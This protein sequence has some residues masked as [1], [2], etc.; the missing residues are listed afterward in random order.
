MNLGYM[1][2]IFAD[3]KK[4]ICF[5]HFFALILNHEPLNA[6]NINAVSKL[7]HQSFFLLPSV[8]LFLKA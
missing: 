3:F 1:L 2:K 5:F 8:I 7:S 6:E 4:L